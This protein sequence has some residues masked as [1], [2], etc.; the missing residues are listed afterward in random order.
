MVLLVFLFPPIDSIA[1]RPATAKEN[2][3]LMLLNLPAPPPPNPDIRPSQVLN[4]KFY[5]KTKP[6]PD[7]APIA[8]IMAYWLNMAGE[9]ADLN[10]NPEPS[11]TTLRR[12]MA[13]IE[14]KPALLT[15]YLEIFPGDERSASFVRS[16][17]ERGRSDGSIDKSER[18]VIK[19]WLTNKTDTFSDDL[20]R[21]AEQAG[22]SGEYVTGHDDLLALTRVDY[23]KARPIID[24]I[25]GEGKAGE[26][27]AKWA[28][29]RH[30]LDSNSLG[31]IDRYRDELKAVVEDKTA[32]AGMR[33]LAFDALCKEKEWS[34]RDDWYYTL[35]ADETLADLKVNGQS[36][37]GLTTLVMVSPDDKYTTK[38]LE[39]L[40][41]SNATV[42]SAA[43]KNLV[44]K[45]NV[46][47]DPEVIRALLPWLEDPKWAVDTGNS[48]YAIISQLTEL[49]M[50]ESVPGLIKV[51][52]EKQVRL[53]PESNIAANASRPAYNAANAMANAAN[54]MA[55]YGG[56]RFASTEQ[57]YPHRD[58]AVVALGKQKDMRAVPPLRR[59]LPEGEIYQQTTV[60]RALLACGGFTVA[61]Q[62]TALERS[63]KGL[64]GDIYATATTNTSVFTGNTPLRKGPPTAA[65]ISDMLANELANANEISD[66]LA[67]AIVDRIEVLDKRDKTLADSLRKMI[68]KW[69]NDAINLLLLRDL[70]LGNSTSDAVVRLLAQRK[71]IREKQANDVFDIKTGVPL[72]VGTAPCLLD[73][74]ADAIALLENGEAEA[75][76]ALFAC[77]RMI[78]MPLPVPLAVESLKSNVPI[79]VTAAELYLDSEDS[80]DAR[81]AVL[82]RHPNEARIMGASSAF[83]TE[84]APDAASDTLWLLYQ[85]LG[86]ESLYNGWYGSGN[87]EELT[88]MEKRLK[89]EVLDDAKLAGVYS[90]KGNYVRIYNDRVIF[91]WDEDDSRYRERP[92]TKEEFDE[93][94][95]YIAGNKLDSM[96]PLLGCGGEYCV[97]EELLMLGKNGG[98][99]LY[100]NGGP[101]EVLEGL[102][103]YFNGLKQAPSALKY[104]LSRD[105]PGLEIVIAS[106]D[107]HIETVWGG[108]GDLRVAASVTAVR[109][110]VKSELEKIDEDADENADYEATAEK[111]RVVSEK[112]KYDGYLWY[113]VKQNQAEP[114]AVQ[115]P[116][117]EFIP[118]IDGLA[119]KPTRERWKARTAAIEIRASD[120]GLFKVVGGKLIKIRSGNYET[121]V[122]TSN[123]RW[124]FATKF[125]ESL[126]PQM[127]RIDLLTSKEYGVE[128]EGYGSWYASAYVPSLNKI[129]VARDESYDY[130]EFAE[131]S[132][133][134]ITPDDASPESMLLV[135]PASGLTAPLFAEFRPIDQQTFRP[136][137]SASRPGEFWVAMPDLENKETRI[138][139][140]ETKF[141]TFKKVLS[142][143]KIRFNSM[144]MWVDQAA[145]KIYFVYRGHL[146][147]LPLNK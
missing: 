26:V 116:D 99:R 122:I 112:R 38:M 48:R 45:L 9:R 63:A 69:Q 135:D 61:E 20:A 4:K 17:Y 132:E 89:K 19:K 120:E 14:K 77:A 76:A 57:Y 123:G 64:A 90:Y 31:D 56:G 39:L 133:E 53:T 1:F 82:A 147:S 51:L 84:G 140:L 10:F 46:N 91:S 75:R 65:Q 25:S 2:V 100:A 5:D 34:G 88:G 137:Q 11:D 79:L 68:L 130:D 94:K 40:R 102:E 124:V 23:E 52:D 145:S 117:V 37:T 49:V 42:R 13:E 131:P 121:P 6:P 78:R 141:F 106:D 16:F 54:A 138:G 27:L 81:A 62:L 66:D 98:R 43:I 129:L 115:P 107:L 93:I 71:D 104:A 146:L 80:P 101:H 142:V 127:V 86:D 3:L 109:E 111:K 7:N 92:L 108:T 67:R 60:V 59:I 134:D 126:G 22:N 103:K 47:S 97:A 29:Y 36:Y 128:T 30:A 15:Q 110:K 72:A 32:T 35:L 118:P 8:D 24:R 28:R 70:K 50:P 113:S 114:G 139:I 73:D 105:V 18:S 12:I 55:N 143:P 74:N 119:V 96:P 41:S 95:A 33:D 125:S 83:F 87:D 85:S 144:D 136:L 58:L 21:R 44:L